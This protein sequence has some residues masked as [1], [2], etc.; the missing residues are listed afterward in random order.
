[1]D[2]CIK[3]FL[4]LLK[5]YQG[6]IGVL[7]GLIFGNKLR[8]TGKTF[9]EIKNTEFKNI[10]EE[11]DGEGGINEIAIDFMTVNEYL[12]KYSIDIDIYNSS[13]S[14]R[15]LRNIEIVFYKNNKIIKKTIPKDENTMRNTMRQV[16]MD[17]LSIVNIRAKE[18]VN[19]KI[20]GRIVL[21]SS[22]D[23]VCFFAIQNKNNKLIKTIIR[24]KISTSM[25]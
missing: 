10:K 14:P 3:T 11:Q 19:Y 12:C 7:I 1:M 13:E 4:E 24:M 8:N 17:D 23:K 5:D 18:I 15:V 22:Y 25:A 2:N 16:K 20:G 6:I 9:I 21:N